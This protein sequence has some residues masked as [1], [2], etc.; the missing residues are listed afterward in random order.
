MP[1]VISLLLALLFFTSCSAPVHSW[2]EPQNDK[3]AAAVER[4]A[5]IFPDAIAPPPY[6]FK[7]AQNSDGAVSDQGRRVRSQIR[8]QSPHG[9]L[10]CSHAMPNQK[11]SAHSNKS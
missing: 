6:K 9:L 4:A 3:E 11:K 8:Q 5:E 2:P 10:I 7:A 1:H